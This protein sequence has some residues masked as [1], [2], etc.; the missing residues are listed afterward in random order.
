MVNTMNN[1]KNNIEVGD[2][3]VFHTQMLGKLVYKV[4][5]DCLH[6]RLIS[7]NEDRHEYRERFKSLYDL[8]D[9]IANSSKR[10]NVLSINN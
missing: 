1:E 6:V 8:E 3:I 10:I 5:I 9:F 4:E 2:L 7:I